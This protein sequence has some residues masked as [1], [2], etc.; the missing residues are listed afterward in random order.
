[1]NWRKRS[2]LLSAVF[3][4]IVGCAPIVWLIGVV[5]E[6]IHHPKYLVVAPFPLLIGGVF[7]WGGFGTLHYYFSAKTADLIVSEEGVSYGEQ[8]FPWREIGTLSAHRNRGKIQ[9]RLRRRG[10][11]ALDRHLESNDGMSE[12]EYS[13]LVQTLRLR[14]SPNFPHVRFS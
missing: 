7:A 13:A 14:V 11:L 5:A 6:V 9:L 1:M 4:C 12:P 2:T 3:L 10:W 8:R